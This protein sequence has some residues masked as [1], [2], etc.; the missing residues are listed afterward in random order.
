MKNWKVTKTYNL[1]NK[2]LP[3]SN[4]MKIIKILMSPDF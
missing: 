1:P 3:Q 2:S 4:S